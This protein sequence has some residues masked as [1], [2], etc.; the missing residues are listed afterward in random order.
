ME[1][2]LTERGLVWDIQCLGGGPNLAVSE[3]WQGSSQQWQ[4]FSIDFDVPS[5]NC[6][7]QSLT[8]KLPARVPAEQQISGAIWFDDL[9]IQKIQRLAEPSVQ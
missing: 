9:R 3:P 6:E 1:N 7:A 2:L 5:L 4:R 8:L